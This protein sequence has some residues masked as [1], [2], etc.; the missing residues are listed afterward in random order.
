MTMISHALVASKDLTINGKSIEAGTPIGRIELH[1]A[2]ND[3]LTRG[4]KAISTGKACLEQDIP[5]PWK[6]IIKKR[7]DQ[8]AEHAKKKKKE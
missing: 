3:D 2:F 7:K 4:G 8:A 5:E 1:E 6:K